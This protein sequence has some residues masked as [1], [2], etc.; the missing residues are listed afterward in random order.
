MKLQTQS[1]SIPV[2]ISSTHCLESEIHARVVCSEVVCSKVVCSKV[3]CSE[4]VC[5]EV[6][7]SKVVCF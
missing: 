5:S 1:T 2:L 7:C 6:V 3:V 4:V